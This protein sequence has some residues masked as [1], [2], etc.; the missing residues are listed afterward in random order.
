MIQRSC[1][2]DRGACSPD[3]AGHSLAHTSTAPEATTALCTPCPSFSLSALGII[4]SR[5]ISYFVSEREGNLPGRRH[6]CSSHRCSLQP[7]RLTTT[8]TGAP[9]QQHI[10]RVFGSNIHRADVSSSPFCDVSQNLIVN[11][12]LVCSMYGI[13]LHQTSRYFR[14]FPRDALVLTVA[15]RLDFA[16]F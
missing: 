10:W 1:V 7:R 15:V 4:R 3:C 6:V 2:A 13:T 8:G 9:S 16:C 5:Y 14:L 12:G 11:P